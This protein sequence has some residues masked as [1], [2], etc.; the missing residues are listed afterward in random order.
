[1]GS[2]LFWAFWLL[3]A[4]IGGVGMGYVPLY[5]VAGGTAG[6]LLAGAYP[7]ARLLGMLLALAPGA[8]VTIELATLI[9]VNIV[10]MAG[11]M[12]PEAPTDLVIPVLVG[13]ST[14]LVLV[15]AS[16]LP[17]REGGLGRA[18]A[19]CAL[20]GLVGIVVTALTPPYSASRPK[21]FVAMHTTDGEQSALLLAGFGPDG[22]RPLLPFLADAKVAPASWIVRGP[23]EPPVTHLLPAPPP[24]MPVP[25][26][27]AS[28]SSYDSGTD[29]RRVTLHIHGGSPKQVLQIPAQALLG[30]SLGEKL[31]AE[32]PVEGKYQVNLEG[33][34]EAGVD[35]ELVLRGWQPVEIDLRGI[36]PA[37]ADAAEVRALA[38]RLP[39]WVNLTAQASRLVHVKI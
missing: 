4:T 36:A 24:D 6:L 29:R 5:W 34:P 19:L 10:P 38:K 39:D 16:T 30:W 15:V 8:I 28:A 2:L 23:F 26:A 22:I 18:A 14:C 35:I 7:R 31:P 3:L 32:P 25:R 27:E 37:P 11:L 20:L 13:L 21:R 17:Y 12:P 1:M 9:V 33:L